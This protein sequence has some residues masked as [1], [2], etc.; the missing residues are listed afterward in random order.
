MAHRGWK[1]ESARHSLAARGVPTKGYKNVVT[2]RTWVEGARHQ[3]MP[4]DRLEEMSATKAQSLVGRGC[5]HCKEVIAE[6]KKQHRN[7]DS[8]TVYP[9]NWFA[10]EAERDRNWETKTK[11][12]G[13]DDSA[14]Y[15][16]ILKELGI[17]YE[18]W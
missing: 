5:E 14:A 18:D 13:H 11:T 10:P 4:V 2:R 6:A 7:V 17:P 9:F 1:N 12:F 3:H 16:F 8:I 15:R